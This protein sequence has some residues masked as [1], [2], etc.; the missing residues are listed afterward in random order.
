MQPHNHHHLLTATTKYN[1]YWM[2][3]DSMDGRRDLKKAEQ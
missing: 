3:Q 2:M 1:N